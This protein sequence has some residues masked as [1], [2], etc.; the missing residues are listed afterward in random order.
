VP[1]G[2]DSERGSKILLPVDEAPEVAKVP[3]LVGLGYTEAEN[4]LEEAGY[5]LGGVEE[6]PSEMVPAGVI[7]ESEVGP[8][9]GD[10]A[11]P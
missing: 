8:S 7:I 4:M 10:H 9:T 5:L 2:E 1:G 3:D 6:A 11:G